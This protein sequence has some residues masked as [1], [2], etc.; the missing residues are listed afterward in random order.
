M[1][2]STSLFSLPLPPWQQ[3]ETARS[4]KYCRKRRAGSSEGEDW[5]PSDDSINSTDVEDGAIR[6]SSLILSPEEA[7]QYRIAGLPFDQELPA[8]NFP[9]AA[10]PADVGRKLDNA[11]KALV[12]KLASL[13]PPV[14]L[15]ESP[16][17]GRNLRLRH[18][19]VLTAVLHRSLLQGDYLRAGRA[20]GL[21]LREEFAGR[22]I[23]VRQGDRWGIGAEILLRQ[24]GQG[25]SPTS[26]FSRQGFKAVK[27]YYERL[28]VQF[29]YRKAFPD[30]SVSSL[31][32]YPAMF[33]LWIYVVQEESNATRDAILEQDDRSVQ[34][35]PE[36][37]DYM[38][39]PDD[40]EG[41]PSR[42]SRVAAVRA[43]ELAEAQEIAAR[44]DEIMVSPPYSD[45]PELLRLRAMV[46]L[47]IGDLYVSSIPETEEDSDIAG[48]HDDDTT[49]IEERV[50]TRMAKQEKRLAQEKRNAELQKSEELF[51]KADLRRRSRAHSAIATTG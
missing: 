8:G 35:Y 47:W 44:M 48:D 14:F 34:D 11:A 38:R 4:S 32:F 20:W 21:I 18:L 51:G 25:D 9:H 17:H 37:E 43:K 5:D 27:H 1:T 36:E 19:A 41:S 28:I 40:S 24:H 13:D 45:S 16:A 46:S 39:S 10:A 2:P 42:A 31:H 6:R 7:H 15:P 29:P 50:E 26:V 33:G 22:S 49:L 23:D 12:G 30:T 3:P